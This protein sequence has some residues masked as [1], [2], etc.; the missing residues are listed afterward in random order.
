MS[1]LCWVGC[2]TGM[3]IVPNGIV[4]VKDGQGRAAG[5]GFVQFTSPELVDQALTKHKEKIGHRW[6]RFP[7][8]HVSCWVW[9]SVVF[10]N[11]SLVWYGG[12]VC[13]LAG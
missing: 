5:D 12:L 6:A 7:W 13:S 1:G 3:A 11:G 8:T 2:D 4:I 10:I 9:Y